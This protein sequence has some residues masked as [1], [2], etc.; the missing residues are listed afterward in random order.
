ML[1]HITIAICL[2]FSMGVIHGQ[3]INNSSASSTTVHGG[4]GKEIQYVIPQKPEDISPLLIGEKIPMAMLPDASGKQVDLNKM[5][6]EMPT[7]LIFYRGGWCPYCSKQLAGLQQAAPQLKKLGY[8][9]IAVS[10]DAPGGLAESVKKESLGYTLL[11]DADLDLSKKFGIA[12]K[13]PKGYWDML[14][15]TTEAKNKDM[16]LPVPSVFILD[17]TGVIQFEYINPDF[18]QRLNPELLKTVATTIKK[19]IK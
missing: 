18:K 4:E 16:L 8:Q 9:L 7:I 6:S 19:D 3:E 2:V 11:S 13:A 10:T 17:R 15:K 5:V 1:K 14:S 12:F